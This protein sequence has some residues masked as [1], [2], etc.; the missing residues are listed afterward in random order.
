MTRVFD[1]KNIILLKID[2]NDLTSFLIDMDIDDNGN[3]YYP[4][5][6]LASSIMNAIPEYVYAN[7]E[8]P[9]IPQT[10]V[11][12]KLREAAK[13]I[14][15]I[16][17]YDIMRKW[18]LEGDTS[19]KDEVEKLSEYNR[20]EFG[21]LL[22]HLLLREF[23]TTIPLVS[24]VY[25][26]DAPGVAAHGFDAVHISPNENILWLGESKIYADSKQGV[27]ALLKDLSEHFTRDYL[28]EQFVIIKKNL[29]NNTIPQREEWIK[30]LSSC[31]KL[32]D[33]INMINIP[34]LCTYSHDIY[35]IFSDMNTDASIEYHEKNVRE[36]KKYFDDNNMHPLKDRLNVIL[37]LFPVRDKK[38]L[39]KILHKKLWHMQS[40]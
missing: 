28:D 5:T 9:E 24:K 38:E 19:V 16:K 25:F 36:L 14:Y 31:T 21:E 4:L 35:K 7:Y 40:I 8:N 23:K 22:L 27:K 6:E 12:D 11:V 39:V 34:M 30:I 10:D 18:Y 33:K 26:K 2:E 17:D 1:K 15:K 37:L 20:G 32:S 3:P 29:K 13:S